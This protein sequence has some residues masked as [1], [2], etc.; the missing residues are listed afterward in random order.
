MEIVPFY[1]RP[2]ISPELCGH[3][4]VLFQGVVTDDVPFHE[5]GLTSFPLTLQKGATGNVGI[6]TSAKRSISQS[7]FVP[8]DPDYPYIVT[9]LTITG[10]GK[11]ASYAAPQDGPLSDW[12]K[13]STPPN[14]IFSNRVSGSSDISLR[15]YNSGEFD[16]DIPAVSTDISHVF[17]YASCVKMVPWYFDDI[18]ILGLVDAHVGSSGSD[19]P[20]LTVMGRAEVDGHVERVYVRQPT[21]PLEDR[22]DRHYALCGRYAEEQADPMNWE[23][24]TTEELLPDESLTTVRCCTDVS[25]GSM[26]DAGWERTGSCD[27]YAGSDEGW[28]CQTLGWEDARD[29]CGTVGG[30]LCTKEEIKAGCGIG[31]GC[32]SDRKMIWTSTDFLEGDSPGTKV[33]FELRAGKAKELSSSFEQQLVCTN[34]KLTLLETLEKEVTFITG[35]LNDTAKIVEVATDFVTDISNNITAINQYDIAH[36]P[37]KGAP[38]WIEYNY[39]GI[40]TLATRKNGLQSLWSMWEIGSAGVYLPDPP[41]ISLSYELIPNRYHVAE[42]KIGNR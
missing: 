2:A 5:F 31:T 7:T 29:F 18:H 12:W 20:G 4:V 6:M 10:T 38:T 26:Q 9:E 11:L 23:C 1:I 36:L 15:L 41:T 42:F 33:N 21:T 30:R 34:P 24:D 17:R 39:Q 16:L 8:S 32:E 25:S 22:V 3:K 27:V 37:L 35:Y 14:V 28:A 40:G 13:Y 19:E